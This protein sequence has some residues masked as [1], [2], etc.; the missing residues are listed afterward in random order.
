MY[1]YVY[2]SVCVCVF[3]SLFLIPQSGGKTLES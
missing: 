1:I 3:L 2:K